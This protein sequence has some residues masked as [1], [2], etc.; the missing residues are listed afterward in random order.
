MPLKRKHVS[1]P[2]PPPSS[3]T[4]PLASSTHHPETTNPIDND[5]DVIDHAS[6]TTTLTT[7]PRRIVKAKFDRSQPSPAGSAIGSSSLET[8]TQTQ[9]RLRKKQRLQKYYEELLIL[10]QSFVAYVVEIK[11]MILYKFENGI[12]ILPE[13]MDIREEAQQY[14]DHLAKIK[15]RWLPVN[16]D[17]LSCGTNEFGQLGHADDVEERKRPSL[18][19][20]LRNQDI[21]EVACGGLHNVAVSEDGRVFTWGC[22][23]D[24][25]LGCLRAGATAYAPINLSGFIPSSR[26]TA[27]GLERPNY[28]WSDFRGLARFSDPLLELDRKYEETIVSV[29]A[30]DCHCL[31][32]SLTGR[33]YFFGAYKCKEGMRWGDLPPE[34]DSR[35]HPKEKERRRVPPAGKRD[36]P[37]H[38][39]Q[40]GGEAIQID[41]AYSISAAVV[42]RTVN[43]VVK[44]QC[45]T[46]GLGECGELAR[47]VFT[48]IKK[49]DEEIN[50]IPKNEIDENS[51]LKF[52]VD[53]VR[54]E[55]IQPGPA[56]FADGFQ[57]RI[58]EQV[59][60]GGYHILVIARE[61][62]DGPSELYSAGLNQ[63]GQLGLP[64]DDNPDEKPDSLNKKL[65]SKNRLHKIDYFEGMDIKKAAAGE[66]FSLCLDSTGKNLYGFGRTCAGQL[67]Y[68]ESAPRPGSFTTE[69]ISIYLEY[70]ADGTPKENPV[71]RDIACGGSHCFAW[72]E[73]GV[74]YS[75][76]YGPSGALGVGNVGDD[77][78]AYRPVKVD[79]TNGINRVREKNGE[80]PLSAA[81]Q[82][83]AGGGQ[84]SVMV[85]TLH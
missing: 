84:H 69:P 26:E 19:L 2:P 52:H 55:Y 43:G 40:L 22:N 16:G 54:D 6:T 31:A 80:L 48:P 45:Y 18:I 83:V 82:M 17:V 57:D 33:V 15:R 24:G 63:Y 20:T 79:V 7:T 49:S 74:L 5:H 85:A 44:Q 30:G 66:H 53:K 71:I 23:D 9:G 37:V 28:T 14:M 1:S 35:I 68:T 58:V 72:T 77:D 3:D 8:Q 21:V 41:C 60:C 4:F 36:W 50:R 13:D 78:S 81:L 12:E 62:E 59:A 25:S 27:V 10:N 42:K 47:D 38:V 34:D 67:G 76:G 70:H 56:L 46:W 61:T 11:H 64:V 65:P 51:Y 75:W 39:S 29:A 73:D 32:L